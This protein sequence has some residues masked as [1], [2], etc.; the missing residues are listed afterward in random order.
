MVLDYLCLKIT[1]T[2]F[3]SKKKKREKIKVT[4]KNYIKKRK[5]RK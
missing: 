4:Y 1:L 3:F 5:K 2:K